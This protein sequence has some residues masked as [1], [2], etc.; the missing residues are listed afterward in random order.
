M[1]N[2]TGNPLINKTCISTGK[3]LDHAV[4]SLHQDPDVFFSLFITCGLA[5]SFEKKD[6]RYITGMSGTELSY[7]VLQRCGIDF[8]R[9]TPRHTTVLSREY[10]AGYAIAMTQAVTGLSFEWITEIF[11]VS[12]VISM[13]DDY[14]NRSVRKLPWQMNESDRKSAIEDIKALFPEELLKAGSD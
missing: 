7:E 5:G 12:E 14:H 3:M 13:Y 1:N 9:I 4:R 2:V 8:E 11:P 6:I 10:H